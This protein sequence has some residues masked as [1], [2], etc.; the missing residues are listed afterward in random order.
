MLKV[1]FGIKTMNNVKKTD[2]IVLYNFF[3][4]YRLHYNF[5][6]LYKKKNV[7]KD[8]FTDFKWITWK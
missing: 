7:K 3:I 4:C 2:I 6:L 8:E 1:N 5:K